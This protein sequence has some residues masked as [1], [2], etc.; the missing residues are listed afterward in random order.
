MSAGLRLFNEQGQEILSYTDRIT[1]IVGSLAIAAAGSVN[2]GDLKGGGVWWVFLPSAAPDQNSQAGFA[3]GY[4][5]AFVVNG[6][7]L[8]W[9]YPGTVTGIPKVAGTLLYG[10]Y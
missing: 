10:I 6:S 5:P 3:V 7:T 9:T 8:S 1:R 2:V 4:S